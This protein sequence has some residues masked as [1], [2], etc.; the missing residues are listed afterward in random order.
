[1]DAAATQIIESAPTEIASKADDSPLASKASAGEM[2]QV[3]LSW[4]GVSGT[5]EGGARRQ[6]GLGRE[7]GVM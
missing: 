6:V 4:G 5:P 1:M 7:H 2:L 3:R